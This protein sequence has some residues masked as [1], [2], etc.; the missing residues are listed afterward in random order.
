MHVK[1]DTNLMAL[2]WKAGIPHK[3]R[4]FFRRVLVSRHY[5]FTDRCAACLH[6]RIACLNKKSLVGDNDRQGSHDRIMQT[7]VR[8]KL[9][10][11]I[12][13]ALSQ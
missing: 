4:R 11:F 6:H 1:R 8:E 3:F 7:G 10:K 13:L 12:E 9:L 5:Y 2:V